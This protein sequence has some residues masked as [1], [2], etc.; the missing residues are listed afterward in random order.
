MLIINSNFTLWGVV[1]FSLL[2]WENAL[3][4]S[5]PERKRTFFCCLH[6]VKS[7]CFTVPKK[8]KNKTELPHEVMKL[9]TATDPGRVRLKL[10]DEHDDSTQQTNKVITT[11]GV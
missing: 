5:I 4:N 1:Q 6:E 3:I 7:L 8:T 11:S 2:T 10:T 9:Q